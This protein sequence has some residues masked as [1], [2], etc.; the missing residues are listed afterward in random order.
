MNTP[1]DELLTPQSSW[2]RP[3]RLVITQTKIE[4]DT[5]GIL[6]CYR[7]SSPVAFCPL[8]LSVSAICRSYLWFT[9]NLIWRTTSPA[10]SA[11]D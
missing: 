11:F 6:L 10:S 4:V 5:I 2:A 9:H 3:R 1:L 8:L 7:G